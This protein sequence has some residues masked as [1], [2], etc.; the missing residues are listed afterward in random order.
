MLVVAAAVVTAA[1]VFRDDTD[2]VAER[3]AAAS[4][5]IAEVNMTQ[6]VLVVELHRVSKAYRE[7]RLDLRDDPARRE[8]VEAAVTTLSGL[9]ARLAALVAPPEARRLRSAILRLVDIQV[10]LAREVAGMVR[11]LPTQGT[12]NRRLTAATKRLLAKLRSTSTARGQRDALAE[13]RDVLE[14]AA[15]T[16]RR[17]E[18]P[19]VLAPV[20]AGELARLRRLRGLVARLDQALEAGKPAEVDLLFRRFIQASTDTGTTRARRDAVLAYNARIAAL[21]SQRSRLAAELRR[22]DGELR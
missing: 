19:R 10:A 21:T 18:S 15:G 2:P 8:A 5:Y 6:Q 14:E 7:L 3:R 1:D 20:R 22:L 11:Y 4:G 9:R 13:Y 12:V 17:T 16:L